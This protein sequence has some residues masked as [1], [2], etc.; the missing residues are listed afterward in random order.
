M[1]YLT[2]ILKKVIKG[3]LKFLDIIFHMIDEM[4]TE[5]EKKFITFYYYNFISRFLL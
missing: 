3:K 2:S 4:H 1:N 5:Y